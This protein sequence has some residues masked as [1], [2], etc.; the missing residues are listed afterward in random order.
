M[1]S[2]NI[3][4][5]KL[6]DVMKG[7]SGEDN[8]VEPIRAAL[9]SLDSAEKFLVPRESSISHPIPLGVFT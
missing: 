8:L 5:N 4:C 6:V 9:I 2:Q 3:F 7:E 1:S